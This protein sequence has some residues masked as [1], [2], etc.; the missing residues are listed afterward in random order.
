[1][2]LQMTNLNKKFG[3]QQVLSDITVNIKTGEKA[4]KN[5]YIPM[6]KL[7]NIVFDEIKKLRFEPIEIKTENND[8]EIINEY[9]IDGKAV[10][11][12]EYNNAVN[13]A[14]DLSQTM[15]F[16]EKSVSYDVIKQQIEDCK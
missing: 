10:S 13:S 3:E 9:F 4:C 12:A 8:F 7:D 11:K 5:T 2:I 1:M 14:V 15:E 16:Y 6:R